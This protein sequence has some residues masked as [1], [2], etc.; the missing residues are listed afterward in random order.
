MHTR[1]ILGPPS[2]QLLDRMRRTL[3]KI[4]EAL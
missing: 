2:P 3:K 4:I 1:G